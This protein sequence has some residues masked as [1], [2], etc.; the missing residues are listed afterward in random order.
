MIVLVNITY[1]MCVCVAMK[2]APCVNITLKLAP[3]LVSY[4]L[5]LWTGSR[6]LISVWWPEEVGSVAKHH[7]LSRGC[8][9]PRAETR[10]Q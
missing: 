9:K 2:L 7:H 3:R 6:K 10:L 8:G 4:E 1:T 5:R